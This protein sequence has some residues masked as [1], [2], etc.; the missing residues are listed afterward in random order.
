MDSRTH[1]RTNTEPKTSDGYIEQAGSSKR[2]E[3]SVERSFGDHKRNK[4]K[5]ITVDNYIQ[6]SAYL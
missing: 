3:M 4:S 1:G 5:N 2:P 6:T